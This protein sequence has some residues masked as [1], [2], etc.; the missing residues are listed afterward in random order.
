MTLIETTELNIPV[1]KIILHGN[2]RVPAGARSL[3]IFSH[4]SGSSRFSTRNNFVAEIL[5][6][7]KIA[8]LLTD[9]LTT[10]EDRVYESRFNI[11]L[12]SERLIAATIYVNQLQDYKNLPIGYFGASTGAASALKAAA[13]LEGMIHS[14]VS[15]GGRPD[16]AS[17]S[18]TQVKAP[19]LL[20]VGSLDAEVIE[21]NK[22]A[23]ALLRCEKELRIVKG[24]S[25]LFEEAGKLDEVA[26]LATSWFKKYLLNPEYQL[27]EV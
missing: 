4:G 18:L 24:A 10:E 5:N 23:Y 17:F 19:T 20:I 7:E 3:V 1:G 26:E 25:H 14:V 9:L 16:L 22:E 6:K 8:T 13:R 2:L 12:L 27:H 21:L 15:R 11:E